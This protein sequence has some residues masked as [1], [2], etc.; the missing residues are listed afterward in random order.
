MQQNVANEKFSI[1]VNKNTTTNEEKFK[2]VFTLLKPS[3][4]MHPTLS[5]HKHTVCLHKDQTSVLIFV[6]HEIFFNLHDYFM[7]LTVC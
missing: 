6:L 5:T 7:V 3:V 2:R 4:L 1:L